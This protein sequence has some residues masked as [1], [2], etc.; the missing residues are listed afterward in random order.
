M[1]SKP[2]YEQI[3]YEV[4][5]NIL[6]LTL[7]RPDKL[8]AFTPHM[9]E[10]LIDALDR[11]DADDEVRAIIVTG[12]GRAFCA[13]AD[14]AAGTS[15][16]EKTEV[17]RDGGG[18][19]TLRIY[20]CLK[21]IIAACNGPSVGV[22]TT[23]QCAMDVRLGS[24][25]ARYGFVFSRRG[26]VPEACSTWFLPRIVGINQALEWA[27]SGRVFEADEALERGFVRSLHKPEALMTEARA[28]AHEFAEH[29]SPVSIALIRQMMWKGLTMDHPMEAHKVDSQGMFYRG[30]SADAKEGIGSFLDKRPAD[31]PG[32]VSEDMP[33]FFPWWQP[34]EFDL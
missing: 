26:V 7:N 28:L 8:N 10:E 27:Y 24:E 29:S 4:S 15:T 12:A 13:G 31:F 3:I 2:E 1:T 34:R 5:E 32:K 6:T 33:P 22:G 21:P 19:L 14:L 11:A 20:E 18:Q 25:N 23:M 9:K 16:W 30:R 17:Q